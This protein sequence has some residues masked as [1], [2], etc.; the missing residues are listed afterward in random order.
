[1]GTEGYCA[2]I[3][4]SL[5]EM[6]AQCLRL[7]SAAA[8]S[9]R[10][11]QAGLPEV[12]IASVQEPAAIPHEEDQAR[13]TA[14]GEAGA[15]SSPADT[16]ASTLAAASIALSIVSSWRH[17]LE[18]VC[19][20]ERTS[21]TATESRTT[22]DWKTLSCCLS[23]ITPE[24]IIQASSL[25]GG[26]SANASTAERI[27]NA[28]L[29]LLQATQT[30]SAIEP[31]MW[32]ALDDCRVEAASPSLDP[33]IMARKPLE[34]T[35]AANVLAHGTGG[36]NVDGCRVH[37]GPS[38]GGS[39]SGSSA[40]GQGSGWN[41]HSNRITAIDRDMSSGRWP[42]NLLHDG[43]EE[44]VGLFPANAGASAPVKGTEA[45]M[46]SVGA[47]TGKRDRVPGAFHADTGSAARFFYCSK[48]SKKDRG[49]GNTHP[50]VKPTD[51]MRY[52]CRLVT[53]P[54]GVVL[55]PFM[56]SGS[57]GKAALLEGFDFIGIERDPAYFAIAQERVQAP[58]V[59]QMA[60]I[61]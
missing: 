13:K 36:I 22:T 50:T 24:S 34:G 19:A 11:T 33:C 48:T 12:K 10:P 30:L 46:A 44:V 17:T 4:E 55:D 27:F 21:T 14:T 42:A 28:S 1:M 37:G 3:L 59:Q 32:Q 51:L 25:P 31:A 6:E 45:S 56:G 41:A 20:R 15:T 52:L 40:L 54:G 23:Q 16:S 26:F 35:V 58:E 47:V 43:S 39:V 2:K 7:A 8:S 61:A 49:E 53:P 38:A 29:A 5:V 18:G 60:L 9:S 57:T